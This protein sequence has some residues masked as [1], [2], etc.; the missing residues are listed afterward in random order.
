MLQIMLQPH[1]FH[2]LYGGVGI[3]LCSNEGVQLPV[4][5][6]QFHEIKD[7]NESWRLNA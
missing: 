3:N 4:S 6:L 5:F 7:D 1:S 2:Q